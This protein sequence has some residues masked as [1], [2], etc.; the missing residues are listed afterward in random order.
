MPSEVA[1]TKAA[2]IVERM[3]GDALV[4]LSPERN[5]AIIAEEID[6]LH[7]QIDD[8]IDDNESHVKR[9]DEHLALIRTISTESVSPDEADELRTQIAALIAEVGT[10]RGAVRNRCAVFAA[11][12]QDRSE[13]YDRG[14]GSRAALEELA[15]K[16]SKGEAEAAH[17][18]GELDDLLPGGK[19]TYT[20]W[21]LMVGH[22]GH[23]STAI[24]I[25]IPN[26]KPQ[27]ESVTRATARFYEKL[28]AET[29][30]E[31][32]YGEP[33]EWIVRGMHIIAEEAYL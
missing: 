21:R 4:G 1:L 22:D 28:E 6:T 27:C 15:E 33:E 17:E 14:S 24:D 18:H 11:Y 26:D 23:D 8:L 31:F 2:E 25:A 29:L 12:V 3:L 13:Q 19:M 10:L 30:G 9:R 16:I 7:Q 5:E 20:V 32:F